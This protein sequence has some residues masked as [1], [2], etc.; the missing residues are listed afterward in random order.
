MFRQ[1]R[2]HGGRPAPLLAGH[3]P[4]PP[5]GLHFLP[6]TL[7]PW[8]PGLHFLPDTLSPG[9]P[10]VHC[11]PDTLPARRRAS[12]S[13]RTRCHPG[14]RASTACRTRCQLGPRASIPCRTRCLPGSGITFRSVHIARTRHRA[15]PAPGHA[16]GHEAALRS[17]RY[18]S[19]A[20]DTALPRRRDTLP[21]RKCQ[22]RVARDTLPAASRS[23][24][25]EP[26]S[27]PPAD[28]SPAPPG[29]P[30]QQAPEVRHHAARRCVA[31]RLPCRSRLSWH[32]NPARPCVRDHTAQPRPTARCPGNLN[33]L[34]QI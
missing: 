21:A 4:N 17:A 3:A 1:T 23:P 12:T 10:G 29:F 19:H 32:G 6:D 27:F 20:R 18:T 26:R 2:C 13:C 33:H 25:H 9:S 7:A 22:P 15:P 30:G 24:R 5:P 16:A 28:G 31:C 34:R 11:L 8:P 14:P